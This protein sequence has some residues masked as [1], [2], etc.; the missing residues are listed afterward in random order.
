VS[1]DATPAADASSTPR[2]RGS[3]F[4]IY[5]AIVLGTLAISLDFASVDLA[6]P[7][8]EKAFDLNLESVQWVI[9]AYVLAFAVPMVAGGKLADAYG[10]KRFFVI[11][12]VIFALASLLGGAAWSGNSVI[13]FRVFQGVGAALLWPAMI[14]LAC[15]AL[16]EKKQA[17]ALGIIFAVCSIGNSAGPIVG[18][19]LTQ[20][21]S[22]RW[23]L[24]IN[25][26]IALGATV[27][28]AWGIPA[29]HNR[30]QAPR[31]DYLGMILLSLG[32]VALMLVAYQYDAWGWTDPR[33]L[34]LLA[35]TILCLG[36]FPAREKHASEPL[37]PMDIMRSR[38]IQTLGLSVLLLCQMFF[39]VLLYLTQYAMKFLDEDPARAGSRVLVFML[40]YGSISLAND[41]LT[42][43]IGVRRI[44]II[45]LTATMIAAFLL[46][47]I[48]PGG[49]DLP[50]YLALFILGIGGGTVLPSANVAG[51]NSV[52]LSRAG[53]ISGILFMIQLSGAAV[54]LAIGTGLFAFV[55]E[56]NLDRGLAREHITLTATQKTTVESVLRGAGTIHELP[57]AK[58][59]DTGDNI[60]PIVQDAY[61][62]GLSAL[63]ITNGLIVV[64]ALLLT[65]RFIKDDPPP[66]PGPSADG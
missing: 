24:W 12:L 46:A 18:G 3:V 30:D 63:F 55:S 35:T 29:D 21:F 1:N 32:L 64:I 26:P 66:Q 61:R 53:L 58:A 43:R 25:V 22:W 56:K 31:N 49:K 37:V 60:A 10:R 50:Y 19:A 5:L 40:S 4:S 2:S 17:I 16:G 54:M 41:F 33:T 15:N 52:G 39:I 36:L 27:V 28:A 42:K 23:V 51:I 45:G 6:L 48:D 44:I 7:A 59:S 57:A 34:A 20:Y 11:G 14:A 38:Q 65:F 62:K 8:L 47:V 13:A 9:N